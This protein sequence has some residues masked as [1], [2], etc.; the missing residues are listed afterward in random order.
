MLDRILNINPHEKYKSGIKLINHNYTVNRHDQEKNQSKDSAFLSPLARL[1]SKINWKLLNIEY[2]SDD[3]VLFNFL[4]EDIEF[5]ILIDLTKI[6]D[7]NYQEFT[8]KKDYISNGNNIK[9]KLILKS[10]NEKIS[11]INS[12][13]PISVENI[14]YLLDRISK[15]TNLQKYETKD[16]VVLNNF[17]I[18]LENSINDELG[19]ILRVIFTFISTRFQSRIRNN[20]ILKTKGNIPIIMQKVAIIHAE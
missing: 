14:N 9:A 4:I 11:F 19:Y 3:E 15:F 10:K 16:K 18:G 17:I 5:I 20:Y 7:D 13:D 8:I 2:P 12:P 1:L 6:H